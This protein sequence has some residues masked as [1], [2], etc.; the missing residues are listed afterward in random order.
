MKNFIESPIFSVSLT[1]IGLNGLVVQL[2]NGV[3][4]TFK[5]T[6]RRLATRKPTKGKA[7]V[8]KSSKEISN[9][10]DN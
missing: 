5:S 6:V 10:I 7:S 4:Y 9:Q 8:T 3:K 1:L 2:L